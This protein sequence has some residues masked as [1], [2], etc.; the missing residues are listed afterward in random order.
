M[1]EIVTVQ[2]PKLDRVIKYLKSN[3]EQCDPDGI[4]VKV[5]RE[6][7]ECVIA[8]AESAVYARRNLAVALTF[9]DELL[10]RDEQK[11]V[12]PELAIKSYGIGEKYYSWMIWNFVY[13]AHK[14]LEKHR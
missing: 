6:A 9:F 2:E 5:S 12:N 14:E 3:Q 11:P 8:F 10:P 13:F 7:L 1:S 4:K